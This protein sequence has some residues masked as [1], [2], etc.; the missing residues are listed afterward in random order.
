MVLDWLLEVGR[1]VNWGRIVG[2]IVFVFWFCEDVC[3]RC[4]NEWI[5]F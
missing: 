3:C 2:V 5:L 4:W 1:W